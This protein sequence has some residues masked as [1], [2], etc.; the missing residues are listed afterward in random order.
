MTHPERAENIE[1][2]TVRYLQSMASKCLILGK[3]PE[4]MIDLFGYN[5]VIE[6]D[7]NEPVKQI[8]DLLNHFEEYIPL[9][10]KNYSVVIKQHTWQNRWEKIQDI[11]K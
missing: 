6:V 4:E 7:M 5:P 3:A 9:I 1:T 10:E 8:I 11:I 2:M